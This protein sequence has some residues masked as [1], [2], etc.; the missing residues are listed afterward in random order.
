MATTKKK[1]TAKPAAK[2]TVAKAPAKK[3]TAKKTAAK[4][5]KQSEVQSFRV[6]RETE[7]FISSRITMQTVY[8]AIFAIAILAVGVLIL[9]AQLEIIDTLNQLSE[10]ASS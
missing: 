7:N 3:T 2:K 1:T 9:N 5:A 6:S 4:K 8:W 10:G